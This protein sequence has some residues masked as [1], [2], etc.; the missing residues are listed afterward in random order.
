MRVE[1]GKCSVR[2]ARLPCPAAWE[3]NIHGHVQGI[4]LEMAVPRGFAA[5]YVA[6]TWWSAGMLITVG[7][8]SRQ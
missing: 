2:R 8:T 6:Q 5:D 7:R 4:P 3:A 1:I